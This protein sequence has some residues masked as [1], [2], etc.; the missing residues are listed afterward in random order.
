MMLL[1]TAARRSACEVEVLTSR[2][3]M[4]T[5]VDR[6]AWSSLFTWSDS[7][8]IRSSFFSI[9]VLREATS[10]R[11]TVFSCWML[12]SL[13]SSM[14]I[15]SSLPQIN[16]SLA[17]MVASLASIL[18]LRTGAVAVGEVLRSVRGLEAVLLP[19]FAGMKAENDSW[20]VVC[21]CSGT[22]DRAMSHTAEMT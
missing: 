11:S 14:F 21:S 13:A 18:T 2:P 12:V 20:F 8:A 4:R 3:K 15:C 16:S 19:L 22:A 1:K 5:E 10:W 9:S 6:A 7:E 17:S